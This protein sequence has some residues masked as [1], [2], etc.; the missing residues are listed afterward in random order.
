M[1]GRLPKPADLKQGRSKRPTLGLVPAPDASNLATLVPDPPPGLLKETR[2]RWESY[3]LSQI[4]AATLPTD[5]QGLYR[6]IV[7]VDEW[8]RAMR[9]LRRKRIVAGSMGQPTLNPLASYVASREA[10]IKDAE[11]KYGM[12]PLSR[13]KLGIAV[14]QAKLTAAELNKALEGD[15]DTDGDN[16][17]RAD[18]LDAEWDEA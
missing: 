14:G 2:A 11:E 13:M 3:W 10:A 8:T 7:N 17:G 12:T 6:W 16:R 4:A 9:G 18:D 15:D 1:P 5:H